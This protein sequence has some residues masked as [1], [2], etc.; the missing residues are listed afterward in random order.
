[1]SDTKK[2]IQK[3][4]VGVDRNMGSAEYY[5]IELAKTCIDIGREQQTEIIISVLKMKEC[6]EFMSET[7]FS[8]EFFEQLRILSQMPLEAFEPNQKFVD[9][10][11][12]HQRLKDL[13]EQGRG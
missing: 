9:G 13:L 6:L 11:P 1:M 7:G 10:E 5:L 4:L 12:F 8:D 2:A 3:A